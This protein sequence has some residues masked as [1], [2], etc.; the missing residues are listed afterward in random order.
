M[1]KS[2]LFLCRCGPNMADSFDF[3]ALAE[4]GGKLEG[5]DSVEIHDL[6]CSPD[7]K[8]AFKEA[9]GRLTLPSRRPETR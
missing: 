2:I 4:W 3:D 6:L 1:G 7:G 9:I 8:S 5:V